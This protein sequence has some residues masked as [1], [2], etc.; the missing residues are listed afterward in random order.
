[1][2]NSVGRLQSCFPQEK[3]D[4][5]VG[6]LLGDG[7]IEQRSK[8]IRKFSARLR[9]HPSE[10]QKEYVLWKYEILKDFVDSPPR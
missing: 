9:I 4:V 1:M 8:G 5:I 7:R 10:A 2:G 6:T 3:L